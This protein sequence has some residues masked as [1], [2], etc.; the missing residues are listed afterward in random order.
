MT[1]SLQE[2]ARR[3]LP[4]LTAA[5]WL[6]C[7]STGHAGT[8][9]FLCSKAKTWLEKTICASDRLSELDLELA[10]VYARLLRVTTGDTNKQLAAEQNRW[11]ASRNDCRQQGDGVSCLDALYSQRIDALRARPD[12][13]ELRPTQ[14]E[15]PPERLA[16]AAEG[17]AKNM[18]RYQKAIR[19]CLRKTPA[20]AR[21]VTSAWDDVEHDQSIGLRMQGPSGEIWICVASLDGMR[22]H[23]LRE[24]NSYETLPEPGPIYYPDP[25]AP[26]AHACGT[27]VQILDRNDAPVGWLG[28]SCTPKVAAPEETVRD[29]EAAPEPR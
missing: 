11:W 24:A 6:V 27:P 3:L 22:V 23:G 1:L 15:L 7:V 4:V 2:N 25:S 10:T 13:T 19:A 29:P 14:I 28:P 26:P 12:Y 8:P 20:T 16:N 5:V 17:W 18:S 9:S 21:A